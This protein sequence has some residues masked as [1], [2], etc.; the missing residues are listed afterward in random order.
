[1]VG[2]S[3]CGKSVTMQSIMRLYE[4]KGRQV[5][6]EGA[7][8]LEGKNLLEI[9]EKEMKQ[10]RGSRMAMIFQDAL[11]ALDPVYTIGEQIE[12]TLKLHT[13]LN[14]EERGKRAEELLKTVGINEP[15]R[16]LKQYPHEL[17]GG[18]RQRVMI[19]IALSCGPKLLIADEPTTALDVTIQAQIIDL[20]LDLNRTMGMSIILITHD[21]SVVSQ[22][23]Q[24]VI[25]M[26][27]GQVVEEANVY[28]LFDDPEHPYTQGLIRSIPKMEGERP[29]RLYMIRGTVPLLSQIP[30]GCR[31]APRCPR[32]TEKCRGE[33]PALQETGSG[34][35]VRCWYPGR[36]EN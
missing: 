34:H 20:L 31:F 4:E 25:V 17:S 12:E 7:I 32:A 14:G 8:R 2:E 5:V 10:I 11:S 15:E 1:M 30:R 29:E 3:G 27:L 18:M 22:I 35:W 19:A 28:S 26:Y 36:R 24:K 6:Y 23:C 21:M 13:Q 9:P 33:M 16:R